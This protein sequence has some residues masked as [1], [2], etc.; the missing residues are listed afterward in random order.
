[1][2]SKQPLNLSF[3][4][5]YLN[6]FT[7]ASSLSDQVSLKM[8]KDIP[9]LVEYRIGTVGYVNFYLAPKYYEEP[10]LRSD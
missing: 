1:M 3:N 6:I 8:A 7:K 10:Q 4:L 2:E 5:G 9:L